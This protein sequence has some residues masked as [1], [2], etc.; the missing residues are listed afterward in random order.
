MHKVEIDI[1]NFLT[2]AISSKLMWSMKLPLSKS[3][4]YS[5][6]RLLDARLKEGLLGGCW[7]V[8][9]KALFLSKFLDGFHN[10]GYASRFK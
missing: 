4:K 7:T 9:R 6:M 3:R 5:F 10:T 8:Y 1:L 2:A